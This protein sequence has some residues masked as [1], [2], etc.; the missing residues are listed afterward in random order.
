MKHCNNLDADG[1]HKVS[2]LK[3]LSNFQ[4]KII[5]MLLFVIDKT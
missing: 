3:K 2:D 5:M 1:E 4:K